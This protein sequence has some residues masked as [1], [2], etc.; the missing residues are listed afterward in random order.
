MRPTGSPRRPRMRAALL[1]AASL[2]AAL[3]LGGCATPATPGGAPPSGIAAPG[4]VIGQGTVLQVG[5]GAPMF[6]LGGVLESYPPQCDGPEIVG[7]DWDA[8]DGAEEA[9]G[10]TWGAYALQGTWDGERF[11]LTRPAMLLALYD[12][13]PTVDPYEDPANAG[14]TTESRLLEVQA[15][16]NTADAS[17][18]PLESGPRNG[19]LFATWIYDDGDL[20]HYFDDRYGADVVHVVSALRPVGDS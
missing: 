11:T 15:E 10:V 1:A 13:M 17:L 18:R 7:W 12:P 20:Q 19:Y 14:T 8:V 6:C 9:N 5:D 2:G 16:L 3:A 4:E